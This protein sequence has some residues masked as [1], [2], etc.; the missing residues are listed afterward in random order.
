MKK[1]IFITGAT[2]TM[3]REGFKELLKRQDRFNII[4]L[5]RPSKKNK[6]LMKPYINNPNI[7]II[8]GDLSNYEDVLKCVKEADYVLHVAAFISPEADYDPN[9]AWMINVECTKNIINAIKDRPHSDDIKL[10]YIG[11]VA[12][13]GDRMP[14]IHWGRVGDPLKPSM[15]D[16]YAVTKIAAEREVIESGLKYW[17]SL[18]QT[19]ILHFNLMDIR[20]GIIFHQP[21]HNCIEWV[22]AHDSGLL[23]ANICEDNLKEE[24]WCNIYNIG[25]GESLR[26]TGYE[27]LEK[28]YQTVGIDNLSSIVQPNWFATR[29]FHGQWYE[30]SDIL[31]DFLHFR[32]QSLEDFVDEFKKRLPFYTKFIKVLPRNILKKKV[33]MPLATSVNGPLYWINNDIEGRIKAFFTSKKDWEVIPNWNG[34]RYNRPTGIPTRLNHGYDEGKPKFKLDIWDMESAAEFRGG[35]CLS[36]TMI[37]GDLKTKLKWECAFGHRF[38]GSPTLVLLGG[39][40]CPE[41]EAPPW[42]YD[43]IANKNPFFAQV[44]NPIQYKDCN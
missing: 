11:S 16:N 32:T 5:V 22:T 43:E 35:K 25:G 26:T 12:E 8:W 40:W 7:K 36:N 37:K 34:Y 20:D 31:N 19:G 3:G 9:K 30:D 1:N 10:I 13:T 23:L 4:S 29:N 42:N 2:G 6:G 17:V 41:C 39:H 28:M 18:R 21:L 44:W 24:F 14:P 38:E 15:Y 27:F 33:M